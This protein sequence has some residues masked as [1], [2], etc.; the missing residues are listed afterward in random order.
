VETI[1]KKGAWYKVEAGGSTGWM[2]ESALTR[3]RIVL[4]PGAEDVEEAASDDELALAG[5]GFSSEV[6]ADFSARH[7]IDFTWVDRME[8]MKVSE[9]EK[10]RFL[11]KGEVRPAAGGDS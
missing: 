6:E 9:A 7:D 8:K 11:E 1:E 4:R 10:A 2:H 5:R 3:K